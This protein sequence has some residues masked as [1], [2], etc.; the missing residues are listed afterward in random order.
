[1]FNTALDPVKVGLVAS[2]SRPG[3]NITG[4]ANI[5]ALLDV[6]RL[7]IL[8]D[9]VPTAT[10]IIYLVNPNDPG[11]KTSVNEIQAAAQATATRVQVVNASNETEID[12]AFA[13]IKQSRANAL[14]VA[15]AALFTTKRDQIVALAARHA[16]PAS[17]SRR[18]FAAVGGLMSYGPDYADVYRQVGLYTA[19]ILKG[20]KPADLPVV[21]GA[22]FELVIN[23]KTAKKLGLTVSRDFLQRVDEI[24]E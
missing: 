5:A 6:K 2:L 20:A 4:V 14:L 13:A 15:T 19:R 9:L 3:G 12:A 17:Y 21:Q 7:E 24:I 10:R 23:L 16:I 22:K 8:R 1:M 18:E 11:V